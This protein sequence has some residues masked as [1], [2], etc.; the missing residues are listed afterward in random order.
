MTIPQRLTMVT[1]G[2]RSVP[3]LREFY[4]AIG[5]SENEGSDGTLTSFTI[6]TLR[7]ALYPV[8]LLGAEAAPNAPVVAAGTWNG[9]TL[10]LN[11]ARTPPT[12]HGRT[13]NGTRRHS[14]G[15]THSRPQK[16]RVQASRARPADISIQ[17]D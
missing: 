7:L 10:T 6:G 8:E 2:A 3:K 12:S 5:W 9:M 11:V 4:R 14:I 13:R 1:I 16:A 15:A 17:F